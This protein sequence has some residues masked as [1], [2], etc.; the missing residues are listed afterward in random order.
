M[1][2]RACQNHRMQQQQCSRKCTTCTVK[3]TSTAANT[4]SYSTI[5]TMNENEQLIL[6]FFDRQ[7]YNKTNTYKNTNTYTDN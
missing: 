6:T 3:Q 1:V 4:Y 7:F 2:S 5:L